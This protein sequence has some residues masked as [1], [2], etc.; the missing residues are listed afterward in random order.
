MAE[1]KT[2]QNN[3]SVDQFLLGNDDDHKRSDC[4]LLL[5]LM[6]EVTGE[7]PQMWDQSIVGF[8]S[9]HFVYESGREGHWFLTGFS[10]G[11][12]NITIYVMPGF[13]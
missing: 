3:G 11:K 4:L 9:Y 5:K 12:R 8:G 13:N 7:K 10:P 1:V 6:K 2:A